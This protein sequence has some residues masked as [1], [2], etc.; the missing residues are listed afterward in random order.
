[1]HLRW[2]SYK[3]DI[4]YTQIITVALQQS[5]GDPVQTDCSRHT[6]PYSATCE[7]DEAAAYTMQHYGHTVQISTRGT[8][9]PGGTLDD[10]G[11]GRAIIMKLKRRWAMFVFCI[12]HELFIFIF[13]LL[14]FSHVWCWFVLF[15][16]SLP[17]SLPLLFH[18]LLFCL[19]IITVFYCFLIPLPTTWSNAHSQ[20]NASS[21][22]IRTDFE[23]T[24]G[25]WW[26]VTL[27]SPPPNTTSNFPFPTL[28][29]SGRAL[30]HKVHLQ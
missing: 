19:T 15:C 7:T 5:C 3:T 22:H 18:S 14:L 16:I 2:Q 6:Y 8:P 11:Q 21:G 24:T 4:L 28:S 1:M 27:P 26:E 12:Q 25:L 13:F 20:I 29:S 9:L 10:K 17:L 23:N 30:F